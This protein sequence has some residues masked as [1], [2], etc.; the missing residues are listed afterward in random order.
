MQL[1]IWRHNRKFHSWSMLGEPC[2]HQS[3]YTD[4][5][6]VIAAES[7]EQALQLLAGSGQDWLPEELARLT[8]TILPLAQPAVV[9][10]EVRCE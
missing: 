6:V 8:P 9:F 1:Y 7:T 3:M 2:V 5:V 10:Q 4:A